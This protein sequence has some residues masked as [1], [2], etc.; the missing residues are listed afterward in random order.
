MDTTEKRIELRPDDTIESVVY[1][2]LAA[3]ARGECVYCVFRD[4]E[5]HSET[6]TMET[7]KYSLWYDE[8]HKEYVAEKA[9]QEAREKEYA[10]RVQEDRDRNGCGEITLEKV[11]AGLM[12]IAEHPSMSQEELIDGLLSL[13]C[14]FT[15]EEVKRQFPRNARRGFFAGM[16]RANIACGASVITDTRD[17]EDGRICHI[18]KTLDDG[19]IDR[20]IRVATRKLKFQR[21]LAS[22][23]FSN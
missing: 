13:G 15:W 8:F 17:S 1:T 22:S 11:V 3:K 5:F 4:H 23:I 18:V 12:F 21:W 7:A 19:F 2:L 6:V 16:R 9:A 10:K 20:F 14:N